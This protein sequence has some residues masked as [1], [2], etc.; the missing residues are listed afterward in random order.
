[1]LRRSKKTI[2]LLAFE[3]RDKTLSPQCWSRRKLGLLMAPDNQC[4]HP[5]F[6]PCSFS[7]TI[8]NLFKIVHIHYSFLNS[9]EIS[10]KFTILLGQCTHVLLVLDMSQL[11]QG[12]R[13]SIVP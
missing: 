12:H 2:C 9:L 6:I 5:V 4:Q 1:M 8:L 3:V 7:N 10:P 11:W 13:H